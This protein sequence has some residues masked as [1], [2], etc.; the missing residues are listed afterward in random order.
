MPFSFLH[1]LHSPVLT[2]K[3]NLGTGCSC[4]SSSLLCVQTFCVISILPAGRLKENSNTS[5]FFLSTDISLHSPCN[6]CCPPA[7]FSILKS[8]IPF[9]HFAFIPSLLSSSS[10][11]F[12]PSPSQ[13][14]HYSSPL[15]YTFL[16]SFRLFFIHLSARDG[17]F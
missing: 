17:L 16:Y 9:S 14:P 4:S 10:C 2:E 15:V 8:D 13:V 3:G 5:Y 1:S 6:I 11:L 12:L 7:I